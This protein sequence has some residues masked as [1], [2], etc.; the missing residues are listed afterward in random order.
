MAADS[1]PAAGNTAPKSV[2]RGDLETSAR[3]GQA[4]PMDLSQGPG[5]A[6]GLLTFIGLVLLA[7]GYSNEVLRRRTRGS[8]RPTVS[9]AVKAGGKA[10]M[11][12]GGGAL[13]LGLAGLLVVWVLS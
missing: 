6:F 8:T 12:A 11:L 5:Q 4:P 2:L 1:T 13:V 3:K 7:Y 10:Q 9:G